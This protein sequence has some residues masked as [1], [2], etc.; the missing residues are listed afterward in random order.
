M[1][2]SKIQGKNLG[3]N[4]LSNDFLFKKNR[5]K[6]FGQYYKFIELDLHFRLI[7]RKTLL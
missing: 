1:N 5:K 6:G 4:L 3:E 7:Y 2:F